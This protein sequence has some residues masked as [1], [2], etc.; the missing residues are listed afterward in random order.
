ME[1]PAK[2]YNRL[3]PGNEVRLK[4]AYIVRCT[5]CRRDENGEVAEVFATYDPLTRGGNTP[6]GR[7]VRGTV[8]WVNAAD[9]ADAEVRL[10]DTL[11]TDPDPDASEDFMACLNP[12]SL[13]ALRGCKV[14]KSLADATAPAH[15]QFLRMG[16]FCVDSKDSTPSNLVFNRTVQLKDSFKG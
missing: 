8:H 12:N 13:E 4:G 1:E 11:F 9:C 7:K 16:Y 14:E 2:K 3:F 15:F 5:G 6:D 10:Y